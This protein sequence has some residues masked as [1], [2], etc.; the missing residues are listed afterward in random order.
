M[1]AVERSGKWNPGG[2]R[3]LEL[4]PVAGVASY[5]RPSRHATPVLVTK[6][7]FAWTRIYCT[8]GTLAYQEVTEQT[9]NGLTYN[10]DIKGFS[11]DDAPVKR[12]TLDQLLA[13][14]RVLVRFCDNARLIR[15]AGSQLEPLN[16]RYQL[17]TDADLPG[18]R[19]Y[20]LTISG[21]T[22][23]PGVYE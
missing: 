9:D 18:Q 1:M 7:G 13:Y 17:G 10:V 6:P 16:F 11:P 3:W 2:G 23:Q 19:G 4:L 5:S 14:E 21:T 15:Q 8:P 22:S 12:R 20:A